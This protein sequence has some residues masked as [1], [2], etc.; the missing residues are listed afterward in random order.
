MDRIKQYAFYFDASACSGCKACQVACKDRHGLEVGLLWRRV[1][2]VTGGDWT[3]SGEAWVSSVFAYNVSL[4]CNHC[5][6]PICAE[7]CPT[8]GIQFELPRFYGAA[9]VHEAYSFTR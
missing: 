2:E 3:R 8:G 6:E 9:E 4:A 1:Y 5:L 7:V